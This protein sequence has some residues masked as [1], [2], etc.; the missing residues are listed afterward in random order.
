MQVKRRWR[1]AMIGFLLLVVCQIPERVARAQSVSLIVSAA[2]NVTLAFQELGGLFAQA[3]GAQALFNFGSSGQLAQQIERRAPVDVFVSANVGFVDM[4]EQKGLTI[5]DTN[6]P[7]ARGRLTLWARAD[8]PHHFARLED[9]VRPDVHRIAIANPAQAPYGVAAREALQAVGVWE[10]VQSRVVL[11]EDVHQTLQYAATGNVDVALVA[12]SLSVQDE[13]RWM[14]IPESLHRP[15]IQAMAV[16]KGTK[17]EKQ[18][19]QFVTFV[20]GPQGQAVLRKYG[21]DLPSRK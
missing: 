15:I 10:Q 5:P 6:V 1:L 21:F 8:S 13:G 12:L 3:T 4:L 19:R 7:Y 20:T 9:I 14:F 2:A 16:V 11:G 17:H 18:A